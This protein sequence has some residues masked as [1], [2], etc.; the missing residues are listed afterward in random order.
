MC[1]LAGCLCP[2][3]LPPAQ[4][5]ARADANVP[6]LA[7][8]RLLIF[9]KYKQPIDDTL[10]VTAEIDGRPLLVRKAYNTI[11]RNA[12]RFIGHW[13][14]ATPFVEAGKQ[15]TLTLKLPGPP[16]P[17]APRGVFFDNVET[18]LTGKLHDDL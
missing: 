13:V 9:V 8:G 18:I 7:P 6:W 10:N 5:C 17:V 2:P 4:C 1:V 15:Q 11:V 12:G 16:A 14:D 3:P